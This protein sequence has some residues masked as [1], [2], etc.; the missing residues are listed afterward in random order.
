MNGTMSRSLLKVGYGILI[1]I[2]IMA[3]LVIL[4]LLTG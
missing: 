3:G 4:D 2:A 1:G